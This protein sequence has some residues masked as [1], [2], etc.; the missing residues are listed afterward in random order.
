VCIRRECFSWLLHCTHIAADTQ[1]KHTQGIAFVSLHRT[2]TQHTTTRCNTLQHTAPH[3]VS[4]LFHCTALQ[5]NTL[6]HAA[7]HCTTQG[8]AFVSLH[9]TATQHTATHRVSPSDHN[10]T[11]LIHTN[12]F[13]M[14]VT[15]DSKV[16]RLI[17]A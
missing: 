8:I 11:S 15:P 13:F 14:C 5:H 6:Q 7:T 12:D 2:A 10:S 9:R 16:T 3:R 1:R 17:R 4:P